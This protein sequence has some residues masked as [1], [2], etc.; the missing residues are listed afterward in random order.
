MMFDA[1][2]AG[3][4]RD[5]FVDAVVAE[6]VPIYKGY[7]KPLYFQ[8]LYQERNHGVLKTRIDIDYGPGLCPNA[9]HLHFNRLF[10]MMVLRPMM[11]EELFQQIKNAFGKV[12]NRVHRPDPTLTF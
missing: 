7:T 10:F 5:W 12:I 11:D 3:I 8:T 4:S 1:E 6:G 2:K 9:E